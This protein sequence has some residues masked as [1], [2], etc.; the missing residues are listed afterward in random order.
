[1]WAECTVA[2]NSMWAHEYTKLQ[3]FG[4]LIRDDTKPC[5]KAPKSSQI[6]NSLVY[7]QFVPITP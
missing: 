4:M 1:M 3:G 2:Q 5:F 7:G 6:I